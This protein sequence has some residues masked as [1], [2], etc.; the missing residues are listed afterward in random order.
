MI[1]SLVLSAILAIS[2]SLNNASFTA[3]LTEHTRPTENA[4]GINPVQH[5][6]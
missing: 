6:E 4:K 1:T 3:P 5:S 2:L